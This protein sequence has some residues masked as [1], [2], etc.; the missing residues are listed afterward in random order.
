MHFQDVT[1]QANFMVTAKNRVGRHFYV[2]LMFLLMPLA[3]WETMNPQV[4]QI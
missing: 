3:D 1:K 4:K 2:L